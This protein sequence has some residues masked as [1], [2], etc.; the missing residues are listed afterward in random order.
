MNKWP[1]NNPA[2]PLSLSQKLEM[3]K[4]IVL[5]KPGRNDYK[6]ACFY[7]PISLLSVLGKFL[8]TIILNHLLLKSKQENWLSDNQHGFIKNNSTTMAL[9]KLT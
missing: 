7:R 3:A 1:F 2:L 4:V 5:P 9:E 6:R 8:E